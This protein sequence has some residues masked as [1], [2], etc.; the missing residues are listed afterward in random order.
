MTLGG[1]N[2]LYLRGIYVRVISS[3][4]REVSILKK[5]AETLIRLAH[6]YQ[7]IGIRI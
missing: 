1:T 4:Q 6:L 3:A 2:K 5:R 7:K